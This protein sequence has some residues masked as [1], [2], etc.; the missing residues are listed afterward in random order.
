MRAQPLL[1][2]ILLVL[3]L[4]GGFVLFTA[5]GLAAPAQVN[6]SPA[7]A[8]IT[9]PAGG[10]TVNGVVQIEG[11]AN[12]GGDFQ[13]YKLEFSPQGRDAYTVFGGLVRQQ[14]N[15]GQLAV[16]DSAS[17]PDGAYN[18]RLRVVDLTGNYCEAVVTGINVQNSAPAKPTD[19]PAPTETEGAVPTSVVPTALPTIIIPGEMTSGQAQATGQPTAASTETASGGSSSGG[20]TTGGI[21]VGGITN[22]L[23]DAFSGYLR[24]FLFGVMA[25]AGILLI[26]GVIF[27]VRRVL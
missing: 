23:G 21:N 24:A 1:A 4:L 27:Y 7:N 2:A 18:L 15:G 10:A 8:A 13:Y 17:V 25:M 14:V 22:A 19:T 9:A 5:P 12:L 26:V 20:G 3:I 6:C 16:W 11:T